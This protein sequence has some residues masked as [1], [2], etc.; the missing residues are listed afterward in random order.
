MPADDYSRPTSVGCVKAPLFCGAF[1]PEVE[2]YD[3]MSGRV[4]KRLN[5]SRERFKVSGYRPPPG[6]AWGE[7]GYVAH[8]VAGSW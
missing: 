7:N 1:W 4:G 5:A 8:P 2:E 6:L 3:R